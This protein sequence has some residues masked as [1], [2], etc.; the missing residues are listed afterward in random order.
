[1]GIEYLMRERS[2]TIDTVRQTTSTKPPSSPS[3]TC[4]QLSSLS[5]NTFYVP[6][7]VNENNH[8]YRIF[9][10]VTYFSFSQV[11]NRRML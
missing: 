1:M 11:T 2:R 10:G 7:N 6:W 8:V 5:I 9:V 4:C 3:H